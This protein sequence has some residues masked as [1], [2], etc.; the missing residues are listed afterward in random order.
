MAY[1][2]DG[3]DCM[4]SQLCTETSSHRLVLNVTLHTDLRMDLTGCSIRLRRITHL[5]SSIPA[6]SEAQ[7]VGLSAHR[8]SARRT[9]SHNLRYSHIPDGRAGRL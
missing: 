2:I 9:G 8:I 7:L 4:V 5:R 1:F 3:K 6:P